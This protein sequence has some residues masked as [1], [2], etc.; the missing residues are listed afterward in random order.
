[1]QCSSGGAIAR[2]GAYNTTVAYAP[3]DLS[4]AISARPQQTECQYIS[5][6]YT[7][8][9]D[10]SSSANPDFFLSI[11][12][13][14]TT[15]DPAW[16]TCTPVLYGAFDPPRTLDPATALTGPS[17]VKSSTS[18]AP[19][20][21][22]NPASTPATATATV[23]SRENTSPH[24]TSTP[25]DNQATKTLETDTADPTTRQRSYMS[26]T[27]ERLS[28]VI[29]TVTSDRRETPRISDALSTPTSAEGSYGANMLQ[30]SAITNH[31]GSLGQ[32][33]QSDGSDLPNLASLLDPSGGKSLVQDPAF[34]TEIGINS[35]TQG[36]VAQKCAQSQTILADE[37]SHAFPPTL[38]PS[39]PVINGQTLQK[40][41]NGGLV[42][43]SSMISSGSQITVSAH[44]IS[45]G[46]TNAVIDGNEYAFP[47]RET[48]DPQLSP[49]TSMSVTV[50][51]AGG[52]AS[53][54][55][56]VY[57][58]LSKDEPVIIMS[59]TSVSLGI[60]EPYNGSSA[61]PPENPTP[62]SGGNVTNAT[63]PVIF[64]GDSVGSSTCSSIICLVLISWV[65]LLI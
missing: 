48:R 6:N 34:G 3:K 31:G 49:I 35:Y 25:H 58:V 9:G 41:P 57:Q 32:T 54:L 38:A 53:E 24:T 4:T 17:D 61:S 60:P 8:L 42:L 40:V 21:R 36:S 12:S 14:L 28:D 47:A 44:T 62:R 37:S 18:A 13:T 45:V 20:A 19:G 43:A 52:N 5:L 2:G 65:V 1:M 59:G 29:P 63:K 50:I 16:R 23:D 22:V 33:K 10:Y 7:M 15:L 51:S 26:A 46:Q 30:S 55:E 56:V 39:L 11:P 27:A 64:T